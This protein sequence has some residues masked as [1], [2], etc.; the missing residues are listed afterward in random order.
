MQAGHARPMDVK[1]GGPHFAPEKCH[2]FV[3][4]VYRQ[5]ASQIVVNN[6]L[7]ASAACQVLSVDTQPLSLDFRASTVLTLSPGTEGSGPWPHIAG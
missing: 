5:R 7:M 6:G 2:T 1:V 4:K 3:S